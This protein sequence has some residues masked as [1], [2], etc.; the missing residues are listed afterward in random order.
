M[1][2]PRPDTRSDVAMVATGHPLAARAAAQMLEQGGS[3]VDAAIA[4]DAVMGVVEPMATGIG[5]DLM[6]MLVPPDADPVC[7]NG[8]GRS[9]AAFHASLLSHLP[10]QRLPERHVHTLTV[11]GAVRGWHDLHR[12]H[13]RL[14]WATLFAPA[15]E[16]ARTGFA[17]GAVAAREWALFDPVIARDPVSARLYRA[18][19]TPRAGERFA[20]PELADTLQAIARGGPDAF[21]LGEPARAAERASQA[22]GGVLAA[23][24]FAAHNGE[25]AAPLRARFRG[26]EV[27]ECPPNT[28]G[29]AVLHT[30]QALDALPLDRDDPATGV[31][32]VDRM[33]EAMAHARRVVADPSGN[34]VCTV[35]VDA[36]GFAIT[37]MSSVFKRFGSGIGVAGGGFALQNRGFGFARPGELNGA[38]P[39]RRPYHTVVPGA[40]LRQGR[41]HA[42]F[43]VVGGAMQPQGHV[44]LMVRMAAWGEGLQAAIDA[45]RWRLESQRA[46]A[47]EAGMPDPVVR[48][49]RD[50]GYREPA[51]EG[52]LGGRSDF[53]GAQVVMRAPEGHLLGGSD[54]RKD[55][56]ALAC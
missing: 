54:P 50:A 56:M 51:G 7:Y 34:T 55:G 20:N 19:A 5:G 24:D 1:N 38:G 15:I 12:R 10:E 31:A 46:L 17:V 43:G 40:A 37:L 16:A 23:S 28:H 36:Q 45:P 2:T 35:V 21:Y 39:S 29:L 32:I 6:V 4:A 14:D 25:F 30:L 41:F 3:A 8:S 18:G 44:Q 52:E 27:L 26:L 22:L 33:D 9:P 48:A 53:G 42:G 11:P 47:I 13:G 49:L